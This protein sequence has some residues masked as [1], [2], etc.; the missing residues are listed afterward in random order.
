MNG[1]DIPDKIIDEASS[2]PRTIPLYYEDSYMREFDSEALRIFNYNGKI[3]VILKETCFFP[4]GGGQP[5][6]VGFLQFP[7]GQL[8]VVDTQAVGEVIIHIAVPMSGDYAEG[9]QVHGSIDWKTRYNR[10]KHH[11][12]S[13]LIFSSIKKVLGL[14]EL[15][16][17]GVEVGEKRGRIDVS[18]G[19]PISSSQLMEIESLS[20]K[21]CFE[22]R[23]VKSWFTTRE[24]A[25]RIYGKSLGVT[26]VTP[27]GR[28]RVVEV[29]GWDVAL[30][31]G[32]HVKSTAEIGL[33]KILDRYRLQK[34]VERIEFSAGEHA[35]KHYEWATRTLNELSRILKV[36]VQ[37]IIREVN[38]LVD[39]KKL[40][41]EKIEKIRNKLIDAEANGLLKQAESYGEF[42]FLSRKIEEADA[43]SLKRLAVN[44]TSKDPLLIVILGS[45]A[46]DKAFMIGA[47]GEKAAEKGINMHDLMKEAAKILGG[48]G[49]T[50]KI[51]QAG[52]RNVEMFNQALNKYRQAVLSKLK[53]LQNKLL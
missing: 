27:S 46:E 2:L 14:E 38:S 53:A 24:E 16:Y 31:C 37:N 47:A 9:E 12:G 36:P 22:N 18:Y 19:K 39:E 21:V 40:L 45:K 32:T 49:G 26:E 28:V 17:M 5:G 6:D 44:L 30:C 3:Y 52:G 10:M 1:Q 33:I 41:K 4:E 25:E 8:K 20:N 43:Q 11:T 51:A 42:K 48:G 50:A 13:H 7:N 15:M 34:G 23:K 29:E 35:Y